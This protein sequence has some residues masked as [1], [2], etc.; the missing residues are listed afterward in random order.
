M[1]KREAREAQRQAALQEALTIA[2][3]A[4]SANR[5]LTTEELAT[6]TAKRAEAANIKTQLEATAGLE[7]EATRAAAALSAGAAA[8]A[9]HNNEQD[10]PF[11]SLGEQMLAVRSSTGAG[12]TI[13]PRLLGIIER[14]ASGASEGV[15]SDAGFLVQTDFSTELFKKAHAAGQLLGRVR[16]V[17]ISAN[18]NGFKANVIDESSR[19]TGSR[20]G[21]IQVYWAAEA[22]TTTAKKP[23]LR[24]IQMDLVKLFGLYYATDELMQDAAALGSIAEQAF[25]EEFAFVF[26]DCIV[27]GTGVGQPLGF[28]A[29]GALVTISKEAGQAA[30][31][32]VTENLAKM[33]AAM[34]APNKANAVWL[35][36]VNVLPQL[37]TL[38]IALGASSQPVFLPPGGFSQAPYG[39]IFGK[40]VLE[41]EQAAAIGDLGDIAFVDLSEYL[42]IE[43]GGVQ[44]ASSIHVQFLTDETTFRWTVRVNGQP[45]WNL[46]LTPYK[47]TASSLSPFVTLQ[48]R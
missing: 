4:E 48:A 44:A 47:G 7:D 3:A 45:T 17:P 13:D 30:D 16:H 12:R 15:P 32:I 43:K 37:L 39:T 46:P 27:R 2:R 38:S 35:T 14:A 41:I 9:L 11:R 22:G 23:K 1:T 42:W 5:D 18:A 34:P 36:N 28:M 21:G 25:T 10:R 20:W 6:V 24:Q 33:Y 8:G 26:D 31:S 40:P 19:A 29:S